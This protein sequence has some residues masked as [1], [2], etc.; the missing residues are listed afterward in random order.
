LDRVRGNGGRGESRSLSNPPKHEPRRERCTER[1]ARE[2]GHMS[3]GLDGASLSKKNKGKEEPRGCPDNPWEEKR[4]GFSTPWK[5]DPH[6]G[7]RVFV[8]GSCIKKGGGKQEKPFLPR[9]PHTSRR[10]NRK[11]RGDKG[12]A[13]KS[14]LNL[15]CHN[16]RPRRKQ[17]GQV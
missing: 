8:R 4:K 6:G 12:K 5:T 10:D 3:K 14:G 11:H 17:A 15:R 16:M 9:P 13:V 7:D 2:Q 1:R